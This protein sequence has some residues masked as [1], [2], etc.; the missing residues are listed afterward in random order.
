MPLRSQ[1]NRPPD[2]RRIA[3]AKSRLAGLIEEGQR[4]LTLME[5]HRVL[6]S[7]LAKPRL[8]NHPAR[9]A[10]EAE[11]RAMWAAISGMITPQDNRFNHG[12]M[13]YLFGNLSSEE[14]Q[15]VYQSWQIG[16]PANDPTNER[17]IVALSIR[18]LSHP[19]EA[20]GM[21]EPPF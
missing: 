19:W 18:A 8:A 7:N 16:V 6:S 13:G 20:M 10:A 14:R 1:R 3:E 17:I 12:V 15:E 21:W 9:A 2:R 5:R 4:I 11:E